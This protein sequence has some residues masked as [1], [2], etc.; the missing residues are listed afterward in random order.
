M[1]GFLSLA[2]A[3]LLCGQ[4]PESNNLDLAG[5]TLAG[6]EGQGFSLTSADPQAY[7]VRCGLN[8]ADAGRA[9]KGVLR[10]V[11][12]VPRAASQIVFHAHAVRPTEAPAD[13]KLDVLLLARG[14]RV[15]PKCVHSV[16]GWLPAEGLETSARPTQYSWDVS[17]LVG[18]TLQVVLIDEDDRPGHSLFC[19]GFRILQ[20]Q[21][22]PTGQFAREMVALQDKHNLPALSRYDS[23]RFTALSNAGEKFTVHCLRSC[24]LLHDLF[25]DH[26]IRKG[27]PLQQP[28]GRLMLAVFDSPKGYEAYLGKKMPATITGIYHPQSNRLVIYDLARNQALLAQKEKALLA[29]AKILSEIQRTNYEQTIE[30]Q[31]RDR[32]DDANLGTIMHEAAHQLSFNSGLL[33]RDA[34]LSLWLAE[35]LACYCEATEDGNWRGIGE[36]NSQRIIDLDAA[37]RDSGR[38]I[39]LHDLIRDEDWRTTSRKGLLGYAQSWALFH[40]LMHEQ[41]KQLRAYLDLIRTR[42]TAD[43]RLLDFRQIFGADPQRLEAQYVAYMRQLVAKNPSRTR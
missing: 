39:P 37:I 16:V 43:H 1:Q 20:T 33:E 26:F 8:S 40:M 25:F 4:N 9:R 28:R 30:R 34:D 32:S 24:E 3:G 13:A 2:L 17:N 6:W 27:F 35:G 41:P 5:G 38:F 18:Q 12:V 36:P 11:F 15:I 10:C 21:E 31:V 14:R 29:G 22:D 23:K 19:T 42:R 7:G